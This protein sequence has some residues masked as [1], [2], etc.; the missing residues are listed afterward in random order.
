MIGAA[1]TRRIRASQTGIHQFQRPK[2][3]TIALTTSAN[4]PGVSWERE[5]S[6][7]SFSCSQ[8]GA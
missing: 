4:L 6:S 7:L 2:S 1:G 5:H 8:M 3:A